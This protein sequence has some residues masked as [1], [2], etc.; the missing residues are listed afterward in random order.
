[1]ILTHPKFSFLALGLT[2]AVQDPASIA[3]HSIKSVH[4]ALT[5]FEFT[6]IHMGTEFKIVLYAPDADLA[7]QASDA[8][9]RRI[10]VLDAIMS[11]YNPG[12]E[13]MRLCQKSGGPPVRVS[14]DLYHVLAQAQQ[15]AERSQG[16]FDIT[17][18]PVVRL[19]RQARAR[20]QL[21]DPWSLAQALKLV[22]YKNLCLDPAGKTAQLLQPGMLL[23]L[24]GIA[25]G[26]AADEAIAVLQAHG[27]HRALVGGAGDIR[28]GAPP[29][30]RRGWLI[31][32]APFDPGDKTADRFFLLH[33]GAVSTS[34]DAE[35][36]LDIAGV[37]YSHIVNPKTG[38]GLTGHASVTVVAPNGI[39]ADS[40][41][42]AVSVLGHKRGLGLVKSIPGAGVLFASQTTAGV[43]GYRARFPRLIT[44]DEVMIGREQ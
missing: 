34:G 5:R 12:S 27:I 15:L 26:Y 44:S 23:D 18:G 40:L 33:D 7:A 11:D 32:I 38:L 31:A 13:L 36:H 17:V 20:H 29:P 25:K 16:A 1:M 9:F 19:W 6:Q 21:P 8:A 42:T 35:Q 24:G 3:L 10:A 22:G 39:T 41:A 43:R 28:T 4:Q 14:D 30:D 37:R 2:L